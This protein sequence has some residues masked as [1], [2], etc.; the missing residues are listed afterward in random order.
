MEEKDDFDEKEWEQDE[1]DDE[2]DEKE[3]EQ[4]EF[5]GDLGGEPKA[6]APQKASQMQIQVLPGGILLTP[7]EKFEILARRILANNSYYQQELLI[8]IEVLRKRTQN[9]SE[10]QYKNADLVVASVGWV[11]WSLKYDKQLNRANFQDFFHIINTRVNSYETEIQ[12]INEIDL[13]RYIR[14]Y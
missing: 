4:D 10:I 5:D 11:E 9:I 14:F 2:F 13:L 8:N 6:L 12:K 1:F 3:W 7:Q